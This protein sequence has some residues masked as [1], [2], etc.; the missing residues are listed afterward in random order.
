MG[1]RDCLKEYLASPRLL[2]SSSQV[3]ET[4]L[5]VASATAALLL[6]GR[7]YHDISVNLQMITRTNSKHTFDPMAP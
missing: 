4:M 7:L 6:Q 2:K 1:T 5:V 3:K